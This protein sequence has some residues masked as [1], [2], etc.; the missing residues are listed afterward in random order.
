M[1][2]GLCLVGW[3]MVWNRPHYAF[4][5]I[6]ALCLLILIFALG[7]FYGGLAPLLEALRGRSLADQL[8]VWSGFLAVIAVMPVAF[9]VVGSAIVTLRKWMRARRAT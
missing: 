1:Y 4:A 6:Y 2:I 3:V 5:A 9:F 8:Q 7:V